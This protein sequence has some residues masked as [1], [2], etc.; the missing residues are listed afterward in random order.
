[1]KRLIAIII[2]ICVASLSFFLFTGCPALEIYYIKFKV[3]GVEKNW[4]KGFTDLETKA[5]GSVY[6]S[7]SKTRFLATPDDVASTDEGDPNNFFG[8]WVLGTDADTYPKTFLN[9]AIFMGYRE[10]GGVEYRN[11][12]GAGDVTVEINHIAHIGVIDLEKRDD[13][14]R[15]K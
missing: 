7:D 14:F 12:V 5:F 15:E 11:D 6:P 4:E 8:F 10:D 3:D 9:V 1:M 13:E 2:V